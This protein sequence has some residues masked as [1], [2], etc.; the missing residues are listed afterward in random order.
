MASFAWS[1]AQCLED[2]LFPLAYNW[3]VFPLELGEEV[4]AALATMV[5]WGRGVLKRV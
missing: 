4:A 5:E 1:A 3:K 2:E